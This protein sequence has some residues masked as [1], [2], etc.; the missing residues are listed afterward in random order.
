MTWSPT[1]SDFHVG[2]D[3]NDDARALMAEDRWKQPFGIVA[4]QGEGVGVANPGR[5][6]LDHHL[7]RLRAI[8]VYSVDDK[9]LARLDGDGGDGFQRAAPWIIP[10]AITYIKAPAE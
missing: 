8:Q 9:R 1:A 10:A 5:L 4:G 2:A 6:D 7:P 3:F